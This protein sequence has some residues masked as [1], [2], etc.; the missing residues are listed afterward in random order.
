MSSLKLSSIK[1]G[2]L[3]SSLKESSWLARSLIAVFVGSYAFGK[4]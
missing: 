3:A 4:V 2:W 1:A